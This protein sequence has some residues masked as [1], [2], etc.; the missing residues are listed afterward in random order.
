MSI[1]AVLLFGSLAREDHIRG[2]D[3]DILLVGDD[4]EPRHLSAGHLSM[5]YYPWAKLADDAKRGDL[6][7]CHIVREAKALFDPEFRLQQ[8]RSAFE[9]R[10]SYQFE[11]K[12]AT[13]LG[14]FLLR[15]GSDINSTL[16][17]KRIIWCVRTILIARSAEAGEPVFAPLTLAQ[18]SRSGAAKE[19][20]MDRHNRRP[21][22][23]MRHRFRS[24]LLSD[25]D[26]DGFYESATSEEFLERFNKSLNTVALQTVRQTESS[27]P[28]YV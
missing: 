1:T 16:L 15:Y 12:Q 26:P 18:R 24:F 7:L 13:D 25:T 3:T 5:F 11:I 2:S 19:L 10:A 22:A 17:V 21:D 28:D 20:I 4:G 6:F 23:A 9:L 14:W 27:N 8:L